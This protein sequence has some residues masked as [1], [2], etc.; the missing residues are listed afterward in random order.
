[1]WN[2]V[3]LQWGFGDYHVAYHLILDFYYDA[4]L[5][6]TRDH[7]ESMA[8]HVSGRSARDAGS[9]VEREAW[10]DDQDLFIAMFV[11]FSVL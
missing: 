3:Y 2:G 9:R 4:N 10:A 5:L 1:M 7:A 6:I 11:I 8:T